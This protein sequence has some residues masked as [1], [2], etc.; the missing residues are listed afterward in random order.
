MLR[1]PI[2]ILLVLVLSPAA[3]VPAE[4]E[5]QR[6]LTQVSPKDFGMRT[7]HLPRGPWIDCTQISDCLDDDDGD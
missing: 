2:F 4:P 3:S 6:D 1:L 7:K 5:L